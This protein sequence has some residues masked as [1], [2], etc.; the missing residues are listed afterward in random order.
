[1]TVHNALDATFEATRNA[2]R[3]ALI[4]YLTAGFPQRERYVDLAVATL[5]AGADLLEIGVP[6]S[7]PLLDGPAIQ[8]SQQI[9]LE[10]HVTPR[11]CI[12]FAAEIH[13]RTDKPLLFM[14]AYN[15]IVAYGPGR[16]CADAAAAGVAAL[17]V[18]DLPLQEGEELRAA[19]GS[20]GMHVIQLVAPTS[21]D[22]RIAQVAGVASGF[23]YCISVS[24][25]TGT[26]H[27]VAELARPLVE[28]VRRHTDIPVAVGFGIAGPEDA[29]AV[30]S[31]ADGVIVG[32]ALINRVGEPGRDS[33]DAAT[34]FISSLAGALE[35]SDTPAA[36]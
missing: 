18:P 23:I 16:F 27:G 29:R 19:A 28:R 15:P 9:A 3:A 11:D 34:A 4:P 6:F 31:F 30:G 7:D 32:S 10:Q 1:M 21:Q 25:V 35:V 36:G 2:G 24:G 17:I 8:H 5:N 14:G 12:D 33:L 20:A 26:R 22:V 13:R